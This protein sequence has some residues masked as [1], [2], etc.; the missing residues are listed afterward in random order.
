MMFSFAVVSPIFQLFRPLS[1]FRVH[2]CFSSIEFPTDR[3]RPPDFSPAHINRQHGVSVYLVDIR[4]VV[5]VA[6]VAV[7]IVA[8]AVVVVVAVAVT[9]VDAAVAIKEHQNHSGPLFLVTKMDT[10]NFFRS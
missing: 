6:V 10:D 8:V 9:V 3:S 4:H 7:A 5:A 1:G 2:L